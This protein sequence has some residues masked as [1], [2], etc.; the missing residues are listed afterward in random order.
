LL[1]TDESD[2]QP[3]VASVILFDDPG[4]TAI[5]NALLARAKRIQS[6]NVCTAAEYVSL[7]TERITEH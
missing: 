3:A 5:A 6:E 2:E 7:A 4:L 1:N